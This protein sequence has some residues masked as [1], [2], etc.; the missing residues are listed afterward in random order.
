VANGPQSTWFESSRTFFQ[1]SS[2]TAFSLCLA[3]S[4]AVHLSHLQSRELWLDESRSAFFVRLPLGDFM[5]YSLGDT[6]PPLY[7]SLLWLWVRVVGQGDGAMRL[8]SVVLDMLA[9]AGM[10]VAAKSWLGGRSAGAFAGILF[11]FSPILYIYSFEVRQYMLVVCCVVAMLILQHRVAVRFEYTSGNLLLYA[12]CAVLLFYSHYIGLFMMAGFFA[13]WLIASRLS[14]KGLWPLC[15]GGFLVLI[16]ISP[17]IPV[18]LRQ[19][20]GTLAIFKAQSV[21]L[22]D[23]TSVSYGAPA[24]I[25]VTLHSRIDLAVR[26]I[27]VIPGF[28]PAGSTLVLAAL[29]IPM[30]IVLAGIPFLMFRGDRT[31]LMFGCGLVF[32]AIGIYVIGIIAARYL[33]PFVP[34]A[35]LAMVRALQYWTETGRWRSA[36]SVVGCLV[37][38][39]YIAGFVR[40]ASIRDANPWRRLASTLRSVYRDGDIVLFD[41]LYSQV[42]F[43][44]AARQVGFAPR[45]DGFPE[46]IYQWWEKQPVKIWDSPVLRKGDV[47]ATVNRVA[48]TAKTKVVWLVL[49]ET[50]Y[51]DP[52][53]RLLARCREAGQVQ[54][55]YHDSTVRLFRVSFKP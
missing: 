36:A 24:A 28:Y 15:L 38:A 30:I 9:A 51:F 1:R 53:D 21:A 19:R 55:V 40:Q 8:L 47:E 45:E 26:S 46:T 34:L 3:I 20:Q 27:A 33:V 48:S 50:Y 44:D 13:D 49:N 35:V 37:L 29:A 6:A 11:L 16:L 31:C 18:M 4:A 17:W 39:I 32:M 10:Y 7:H 41:I 43:D 52:F 5:R 25:P 22:S 23:P 14:P 42:P 2:F 54:E 12:L